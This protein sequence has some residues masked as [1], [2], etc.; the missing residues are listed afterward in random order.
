[1]AGRANKAGAPHG[2]ANGAAIAGPAKWR[3][4]LANKAGAARG[5]PRRVLSV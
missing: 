2:A 4:G 3:A 5:A 1:M